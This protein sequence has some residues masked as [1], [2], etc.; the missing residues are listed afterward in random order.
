MMWYESRTEGKVRKREKTRRKQRERRDSMKDDR[1]RCTYT[2][3]RRDDFFLAERDV[4]KKLSR[5]KT[6]RERERN[7]I[8]SESA[9]D[10]ETSG[11]THLGICACTHVHACTC[12]IVCMDTDIRRRSSCEEKRNET[13]EKK[14]KRVFRRA[15]CEDSGGLHPTSVQTR[16]SRY[17]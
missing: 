4:R 3:E 2:W 13:R 5:T 7:L 8:Q 6:E 14:R 9:Y 12:F 1:R 11:H 10:R 17:T 15:T 16:L